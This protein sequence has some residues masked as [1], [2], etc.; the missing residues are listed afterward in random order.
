MI[1]IKKLSWQIYSSYLLIIFI[2]LFAVSWFAFSSL[3]QF[4]YRQTQ[5]DL[6]ARARLMENRIEAHILPLDTGRI[7]HICKLNGKRSGTRF[8]VVLPSGKVIGDS[9]EDPARMVSH[10]DRPEIVKALESGSGAAIRFSQTLQKN[11]MYVAVS[12]EHNNIARAV[13]RSSIPVNFVEEEVRFVQLKLVFAGGLIA[14]LAAGIS[15]LVSRRI[16]R[17]LQELKT[18]ARHFAQGDLGHKLRVGEFEEM[19]DLAD[20]MNRMA[21]QLD[22]RIRT[23]SNQRNKLEAILSSMVEGVMAVDT[24]ERI[25]S[26]NPAAAEIFQTRLSAPEGR[27]VQEMIRSLK[28]QRFV[29]EAIASEE[30]AAG[31]I[32]LYPF[33]GRILH[34]RS[35]ALRDAGDERIGTLFIMND[36]TQLRRLENMRRDFAA[37]VSH[38]IKTPITAIKGFVETLLNRPETSREEMLHFLTIIEKNIQRLVMIIDDLLN[39]AQIERMDERAEITLSEGS[40]HNVL[41][42]AVQDCRAAA[43]EKNIKIDLACDKDLRLAMDAHLLERAAVNLLDN[44]VKYSNRDSVVEV[45]ATRDNGD[46]SIRFQ[47]HGI[48]IGA[49]HLPRIFER[50]YR[51]DKGRSR[52]SG[53]TGLGLAIVKHITHLHGGRI[54]VDSSPGKGSIFVI[55]IPGVQPSS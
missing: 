9:E 20:A 26:I 1:K 43:D 10:A 14:L 17:P 47:D 38:E 22:E 7:D 3:K 13:I 36:V 8:T 16:I 50:F 33:D 48:G 2:S 11:M 40:L 4:Q 15:L 51:V 12:V 27:S 31:D 44:A 6:M 53:G 25:L 21:M 23:E 39:L 19:S 30:P 52:K 55:R 28:L 46:I 32:P 49:E 41:T 18:G 24:D 34:T 37:N 5:T 45:I 35:I 29:K 42:A 54:T